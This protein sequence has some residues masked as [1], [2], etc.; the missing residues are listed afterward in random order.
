MYPPEGTE[1]S[2]RERDAPPFLAFARNWSEFR[3][4]GTCVS[5][6]ADI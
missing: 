1:E 5:V 2:V 6:A 3:L 4:W